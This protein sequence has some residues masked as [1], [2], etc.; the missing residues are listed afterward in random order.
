MNEDFDET[1]LRQQKAKVELTDNYTRCELTF[2]S[3]YE[4]VHI[5]VR[6]QV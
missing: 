5:Q 1:T 6:R 2:T 4:K 3:P